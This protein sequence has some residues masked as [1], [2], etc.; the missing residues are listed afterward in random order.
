MS[1][2]LDIL[3]LEPFYGGARRQM[4]QT[5]MHFSRHHWTLVKLPPRR[6]ER[7]LAAAARWFAE[8]ISRG[9]MEGCDL[10]FAGEMMNLADLHRSAPKL[11]RRPS[12]VYFHE[13][14]MP[15]AGRGVPGPLDTVNLN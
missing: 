10:V 4:L 15:R 3:A 1:N 7:R 2:Q 8:V 13:N 6:V 5:I 9:D 14:Q 11:A 12:I